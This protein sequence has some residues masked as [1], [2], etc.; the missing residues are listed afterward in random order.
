MDL[1]L[2][3]K[4]ITSKTKAIIIVHL[5]GSC[6]NMDKLMNIVNKYNLILI[7][8]CAQSHGAKFNNKSLGTYGL[9]ST[10]SFYPGKNLG[11]FGDG[12]AICTN[13]KII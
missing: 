9:I 2:L 5:T 10:F 12:G 1:D 7:E 8:D 6:C 4:K 11:A 3:E 13:N